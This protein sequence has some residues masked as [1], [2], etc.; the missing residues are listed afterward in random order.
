MSPS[1]QIRSIAPERENSYASGA[2]S[3]GSDFKSPSHSVG[4]RVVRSGWVRHLL[5]LWS[6]ALG[7]ASRSSRETGQGPPHI[8]STALA[9]RKPGPISWVD[10]Y[11]LLPT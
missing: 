6:A 8:H 10:A 3:S 11:T 4:A 1:S 7:D 5:P 2:S 9:L